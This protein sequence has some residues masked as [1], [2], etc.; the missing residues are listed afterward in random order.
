MGLELASLLRF[1]QSA[2]SLEKN[3]ALHSILA[4]YGKKHTEACIVNRE[5]SKR[6]AFRS[7]LLSLFSG[8]R[9]FCVKF[10]FS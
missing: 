10:I 9:K 6:D 5:T 8:Y 4:Q 1:Q 7:N 3:G 2:L